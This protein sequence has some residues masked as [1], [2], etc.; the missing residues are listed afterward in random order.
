[1]SVRVDV[2]Q[3][4]TDSY[5]VIVDTG[6]SVSLSGVE[7]DFLPG[8][9]KQAPVGLSIQSYGGARVPVTHVGTI[10]WYVLDD[11]HQTR[12]IVLP[13]SLYVP[14]TETRLLSPQHLAQV[15]DEK[16]VPQNKRTKIT[17]YSSHIVLQWSA[18]AY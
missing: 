12:A 16:G 4:H 13:R 10:K 7:T 17:T 3:F 8:T 14:S 2:A 5:Q 11:H 6:C 15:T 18:Q 1:M 9:L